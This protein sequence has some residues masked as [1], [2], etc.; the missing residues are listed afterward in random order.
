MRWRCRRSLRRISTNRGRSRLSGPPL[1]TTGP[2]SRAAGLAM[3][4]KLI[5]AAQ[6]RRRAVQHPAPRHLGPRRRPVPQ[7]RPRRTPRR[8]RAGGGIAV[9]DRTTPARSAVPPSRPT[10]DSA[11]APQCVA[12][13]R[14]RTKAARYAS[15][16]RLADSIVAGANFSLGPVKGRVTTR[17]H[18]RLRRPLTGL[19]RRE[20]GVYRSRSLPSRRKALAACGKSG[21]RVG[22]VHPQK[23]E[24][25][26]PGS[27]C[28]E[29]RCAQEILYTSL[30]YFSAPDQQ[31]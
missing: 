27:R 21:P 19:P 14:P 9:R 25:S 16:G 5:E 11:S 1:V 13:P 22:R 7:R 10:D 4:F 30:D 26:H 24:E 18:P 3:A 23:P 6:D 31:P 2:G 8:H 12:K 17:G 29:G 15:R 20:A 28:P